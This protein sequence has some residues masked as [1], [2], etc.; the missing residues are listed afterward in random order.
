MQSTVI[1]VLLRSRC[2]PGALRDG[3]V[4][5]FICLLP[6]TGNAYFYCC[7][8]PA[9]GLLLVAGAYRVGQSDFLLVS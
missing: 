3:A 5:L 9:G 6:A 2:K 4:L 7:R 1:I 8:Q